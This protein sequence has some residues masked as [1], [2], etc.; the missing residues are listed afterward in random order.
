MVLVFFGSLKNNVDISDSFDNDL[1][2][3]HG[4]S[5]AA[6]PKKR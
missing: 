2:T 6:G 1:N 4:S 3:G 5:G